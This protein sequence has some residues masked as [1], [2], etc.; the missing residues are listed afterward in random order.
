MTFILCKNVK[1]HGWRWLFLPEDT[2]C[3]GAAG[4][5]QAVGN[6]SADYIKIGLWILISI[7]AGL[8]IGQL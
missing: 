4:Q 7:L 2:T 8:A 1:Q 3:A 6:G 5:R